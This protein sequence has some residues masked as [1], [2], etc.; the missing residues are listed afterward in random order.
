LSA[1][2]FAV[3]AQDV[4]FH[5]VDLLKTKGDWGFFHELGHNHEGQAYT[6]GGDYVEVDVNLFSMYVMQTVVG[7][8][9]TAHPSL[10]DIG[11]LIA[12]RLGPDKKI[13]PWTNLATT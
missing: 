11:K 12:D 3:P 13:D 4:S 6:F 2:F 7:R 10:K 1:A 8:E 9:M 5:N